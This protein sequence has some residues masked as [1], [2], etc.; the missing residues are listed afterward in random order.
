MH[1]PESARS[2][3]IEAALLVAVREERRTVEDRARSASPGQRHGVLTQGITDDVLG[4]T[5][6]GCRRSRRPVPSRS[7]RTHRGSTP[8]RT[9]RRSTCRLGLREPS[10]RHSRATSISPRL[11]A[12][13]S[14][15]R[16]TSWTS[17][18]RRSLRTANA[19]TDICSAVASPCWTVMVSRRVR[20]ACPTAPTGLARI[21]ATAGS[22]RGIPSPRRL[23]LPPA[24]LP[25]VER[26]P[27]R[28]CVRTS[29]QRS[30]GPC[31]RRSALEPGSDQRRRS[32]R[33]RHVVRPG[34]RLPTSRA[35]AVRS[36]RCAGRSTGRRRADHRRRGCALG[37]PLELMP[38]AYSL[39][40][41]EHPALL[42]GQRSE[43]REP[44]A[45]L[46]VSPWSAVAPHEF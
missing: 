2:I 19:A 41:R 6:A 42:P 10:R 28:R 46:A 33:G 14:R 11:R 21:A 1:V 9:V 35:S 15:S 12:P 34:R 18:L 40:R 36:L 20:P 32:R 16:R 7:H 29:W 4:P 17:R 27:V 5:R 24:T 13:P 37:P 31:R 26:A 22:V 30:P 43:P 8:L 44:T 38:K 23:G 39:D 25:D 45:M 3:W